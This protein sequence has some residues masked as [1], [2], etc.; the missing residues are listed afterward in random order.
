MSANSE[1]T[2][3]DLVA[4]ASLDSRFLAGE[5]GGERRVLWAHSCEMPNPEHWLGPHELLMTIGICLP[6]GAPEQV[7]FIARLNSA[8]LA[9]IM[10]GDHTLAPPITQEMLNEAD[11]LNFPVILAAEQVPYAVV[12]RHVAAANSHEQTLQVLTLSKLYHLASF[13]GDDADSLVTNL[14]SLLG[15]G[16][17]IVDSTT[18]LGILETE[19]SGTREAP[20][21]S[22]DYELHGSHEVTLTITEFRGEEVDSFILVHLMKVL[23]VVVDQRLNAADRRA[24][25]S[26]TLMLSLLNGIALPDTAAFLD[27]YLPS[28][29]FV[30][31]SFPPEEHR[32]ISRA[33]SVKKFPVISGMGRVTYLALVPV[34]IADDVK[35]LLTTVATHAGVSS[36]FTDYTDTRVAA[37]EAGKVLSAAKHNDKFWTEFEGSTV[38]VLT[39]SHREAFDIAH[40]VL[41]L[42]AEENSRATMLRETL[43]AFLRNDR[44]WKETAAELFIHKQTLSYRLGK[45]EELTG[46]NLGKS[47]DL[48][49][50]WIAYQA[51]VTLSPN[52]GPDTAA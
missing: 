50:L 13:A 2:V 14:G 45:I 37:V 17:R 21:V 20:Y 3:A 29:G 32:A 6:Q 43:F 39:R 9:G 25:I 30:L 11:R 10:I 5:N 7:A 19:I 16:I 40:G 15:V 28:D 4:T 18:G 38:S 34:G 27:P 49:S 42:L 31:V 35:N 22:H 47:A 26:S 8:G 33:L 24:E 52:E 46:L 12:A 1:L 36:I 44:K 48:S 51:W 41:G 23:E